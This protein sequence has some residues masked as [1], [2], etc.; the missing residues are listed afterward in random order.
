MAIFL[1]AI[2]VEEEVMRQNLESSGLKLGIV[3]PPIS[4]TRLK[5]EGIGI[6]L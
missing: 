6:A 4:I 5:I 2:R 1:E 3:I